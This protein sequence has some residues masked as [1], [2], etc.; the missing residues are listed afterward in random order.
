MRRS[1]NVIF[2]LLALTLVVTACSSAPSETANEAEPEPE[3]SMVLP[4]IPEE[5]PAKAEPYEGFT[6]RPK[7]EVIVP[8]EWMAFVDEDNFLLVEPIEM[9]AGGML[10]M[11]VVRVTKVADP[12]TATTGTP[13]FVAAPDDILA[14]LQAHPLLEVSEPKTV[15]VDGGTGQMVDVKY[16]GGK[17]KAYCGEGEFVDCAVLFQVGQRPPIFQGRDPSHLIITER[18]GKQILVGG[19]GTEAAAKEIVPMFNE[20]RTTVDFR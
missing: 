2:V 12:A 18:D 20:F 1:R 9:T 3:E 5:E 17:S 15:K 7:T 10:G 13:K 6:F 19:Y 16:T 14:W 8:A 11:Y 4:E